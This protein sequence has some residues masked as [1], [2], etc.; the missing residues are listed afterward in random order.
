MFKYALSLLLLVGCGVQDR[1][2]DVARTSLPKS[3]ML[4]VNT[5]VTQL[6]ISVAPNGELSITGSTATVP[7]R[8]AGVFITPSGHILSCAHLFNNGQIVSIE[9]HTFYDTNLRLELLYVDKDKDLALLK[10]TTMDFKAP[11]VVLA[12]PRKAKVGQEVIAIGNPLGFEFSVSQGIISALYRDFGF[13]YN[14][15]QSDTAINLG[16][17]GGPLLNLRGELVGINSMIAQQNPFSGFTGLGFSVSSAQI[18]E[19]LTKFKGI[20]TA[21]YVHRF[22]EN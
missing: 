21:F 19:F 11:Y 4:T 16:N 20:D 2:V 5:V 6:E 22:W 14:M 1:Y 10:P 17:S 8:G 15:N 18:L 13:R 3:V 12:D 7:T 9:G